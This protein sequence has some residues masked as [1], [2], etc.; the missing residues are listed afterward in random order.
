MEKAKTKGVAIVASSGNS[1]D[2]NVTFPA[3]GALKDSKYKDALVSVGSVDADDEKSSFSTYQKDMVEMV[4]PGEFIFSAYPDNRVIYWSGTS[5]AAPMVSGAL[6]LALGEP[7][8]DKAAKD[9]PKL[10]AE[11][12]MDKLYKVGTNGAL[13]KDGLGRG[14]LDLKKFLNE[15]LK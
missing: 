5:F 12:V 1:G 15:V 6:A 10:V 9:L 14:R 8:L 2:R 4:A 7:N 11:K 13:Y 3:S